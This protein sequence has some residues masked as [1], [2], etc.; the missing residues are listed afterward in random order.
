MSMKLSYMTECPES[1]TIYKSACYSAFAMVLLPYLLSWI[2]IDLPTDYSQRVWFDV[3]YHVLNFAAAAIIFFV[4]LRD[5]FLIVR[6]NTK[7]ILLTALIGAAIMIALGITM[8]F[9]G[10]FLG[11]GVLAEGMLPIIEIELFGMA[12]ALMIYQPVFGILIVA[13]LTPF[14]IGCLLYG[15]VFAPLA[16]KWPGLAY[17]VFAVVL[18]IPRVIYALTFWYWFDEMILYLVQLPIHLI[19]CSLYQRTDSIWTPI[20]ALMAANTAMCI[21]LCVF[22][23]I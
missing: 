10:A 19:A 11:N 8:W 17:V 13:V 21:F 23:L 22:Y 18:A 7:K 20:F 6:I 4:F 12:S 14:T 1:A 3:A 2:T 16:N 15:G 9:V 5:Y